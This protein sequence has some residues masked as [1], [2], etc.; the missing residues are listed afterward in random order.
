MNKQDTLKLVRDNDI[1]LEVEQIE[2]LNRLH[3]FI[4]DSEKYIQAHGET[5]EAMGSLKALEG[6]VAHCHNE[7]VDTIFNDYTTW[8]KHH[9]SDIA[10]MAMYKLADKLEKADFYVWNSTYGNDQFASITVD[11]DCFQKK[12]QIFVPNSTKFDGDNEEDNQYWV[13]PKNADDECIMEG[14]YFDI[15]DMSGIENYCTALYKF[16]EA[17]HDLEVLQ[18]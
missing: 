2:K 18:D 7:V 16:F 13:Q 15:N 17:Q 3:K 14:Q 11:F 9:N 8:Y 5:I 4:E 12:I 10:N 1:E 6:N